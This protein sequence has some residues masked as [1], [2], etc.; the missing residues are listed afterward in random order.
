MK[1]HRLEI[2]IK[3]IK[4]NPEFPILWKIKGKGFT[5]GRCCKNLSQAAEDI[6]R[7]IVDFEKWD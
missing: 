1:K 6:K 7:E 4:D 2:T 5:V 3:R